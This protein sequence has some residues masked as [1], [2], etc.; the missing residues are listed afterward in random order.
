M[1]MSKPRLAIATISTDDEPRH[2]RVRVVSRIGAIRCVQLQ[3]PL[4]IGDYIYLEDV[5]LKVDGLPLE[6]GI[7]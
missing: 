2:V 3:E 4:Q 1:T 5:D 7:A 6:D